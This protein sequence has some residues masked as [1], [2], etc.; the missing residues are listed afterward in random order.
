MVIH[1]LPEFHLRA[2]A[3]KVQIR[4]H[5]FQ[6]GAYCFFNPQ[7]HNMGWR[8]FGACFTGVTLV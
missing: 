8:R 6:I 5:P 4:E 2:R 3:A 1:P 7:H